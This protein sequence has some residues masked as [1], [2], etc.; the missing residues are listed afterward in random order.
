MELAIGTSITQGRLAAAHPGCLRLFA[1]VAP[2]APLEAYLGRLIGSGRRLRMR[3]PLVTKEASEN[4]EDGEDYLE[5]KFREALESETF[6][7]QT[8]RSW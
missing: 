1:L 6:D 5:E 3:S 4:A 7:A 8:G 2:F